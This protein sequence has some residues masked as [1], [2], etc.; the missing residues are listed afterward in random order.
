[1]QT[2]G[3]N[4][5]SIDTPYWGDN[6]SVR[7]IQNIHS[8]TQSE[9]A[10]DYYNISSTTSLENIDEEVKKIV[11]YLRKNKESVLL[12]KIMSEVTFEPGMINDTI[13]YFGSLLAYGDVAIAMWVSELFVSHY[14]YDKILKGLL[15][16]AMYYNEVFVNFDTM[17]AMAAISHK[18]PEVREL[19]V[20]VLESNCNIVNYDVLRNIIV[21]DQWLND[22][23]QDVIRD[24]KKELCLY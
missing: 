16:I 18:S 15:Y 19:A 12:Q 10:D 8:M 4:Y 22:Y 5:K 17:M 1:M 21:Q 14:K 20:R 3:T 9:I 2:L 13:S 7:V 11:A 23:I 6:S 24:F